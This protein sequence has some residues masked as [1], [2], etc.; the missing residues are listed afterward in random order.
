M[1]GLTPDQVTDIYN[2]MTGD[3]I[4]VVMYDDIIKCNDLLSL[5]PGNKCIVFYPAVKAEGITIGH[6]V[7][8]IYHE[9]RRL[10]SFYDSLA[11]KPDGYKSFSL[12]RDRLY[13][14][15]QNSLIARFL[16]LHH[17]GVSIDRNTHQH[18]S[19][20]P[21]MASCGLHCILRCMNDDMN[22]TEYN[23]FMVKLKKR[24]DPTT[25]SNLKDETI[26]GVFSDFFHYLPYPS[27]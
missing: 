9:N 19:R 1:N 17:E 13:R 24:Y 16:D 15:H 26:R 20:K 25:R 3:S 4:N 6:Y 22:N 10:L 12:D 23:R 5:M 8:M 14:E 27:D 18:Q 7:C 21:S 2:Q 11:Y